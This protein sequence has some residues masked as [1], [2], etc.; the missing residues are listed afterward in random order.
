[1]DEDLIDYNLRKAEEELYNSIM[2]DLRIS[3]IEKEMEEEWEGF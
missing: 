1:M 2:R 3:Q